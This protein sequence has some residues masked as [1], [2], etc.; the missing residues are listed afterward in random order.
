M[1]N[2]KYIIC[3]FLIFY[4][5]ISHSLSYAQISGCL[6]AEIVSENDNA[7]FVVDVN[8]R[9]FHEVRRYLN[10]ITSILD[11]S[12]S[13]RIK[14]TRGSI[15]FAAAPNCVNDDYI[16]TLYANEEAVRELLNRDANKLGIL[17]AHEVAHFLQYLASSNLKANVC[18][19]QMQD[20]K[21]FELI[22]DTVSGYVQYIKEGEVRNRDILRAISLL[23]DYEFANPN[24]H[25]V[26][27]DRVNAFNMGKWIA[28]LDYPINMRFLLDNKNM[29]I[30]TLYGPRRTSVEENDNEDLNLWEENLRWLD[31]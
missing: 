23:A 4:L 16:G 18:N 13:I 3:A 8:S 29:Y 10:Q 27:T 17:L 1:N 24:H 30:K 19:N 14:F 5:I 7:E 28:Y 25:G 15:G 12:N 20:V 26:I 22:A 9:E 6:A 2:R 21:T 31:Q 11:V